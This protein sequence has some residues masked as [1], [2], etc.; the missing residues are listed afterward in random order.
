MSFSSALPFCEVFRN[1]DNFGLP[2]SR[3]TK[4]IGQTTCHQKS[5]FLYTC[6]VKMALWSNVKC[7][8]QGMVS[9]SV[10]DVVDQPA[11]NLLQLTCFSCI[12]TISVPLS[13][14]LLQLTA[15]QILIGGCD[16]ARCTLIGNISLSE[17]RRQLP[18]LP[19]WWL[20]P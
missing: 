20:R 9:P 7:A 13:R 18:P 16:Q 11:P 8:S 2:C 15:Y 12:Y 19:L 3:E 1:T 14:A 4:T 6:R 10:H 5:C 17:V